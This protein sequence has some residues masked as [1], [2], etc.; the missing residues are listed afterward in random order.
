MDTG[1]NQMHEITEDA[2]HAKPDEAGAR[3]MHFLNEM[4]AVMRKA[5]NET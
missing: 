2:A 5:E 4:Y 1:L 3:N